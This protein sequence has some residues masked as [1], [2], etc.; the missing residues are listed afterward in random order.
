MREYSDNKVFLKRLSIDEFKD[1]SVF[2]MMKENPAFFSSFYESNE[3]LDLEIWPIEKWDKSD[4]ISILVRVGKRNNGTYTSFFISL[5][6][7]NLL[8]RSGCYKQDF[9][10]LLHQ[11]LTSV[12]G[13]EYASHLF[14]KRVADAMKEKEELLGCLN[15]GRK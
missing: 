6:D 3:D 10:Y 8:Y 7:F 9:S 14:E 13:D 1:L 2:I 11:Y 4:E 15:N 12:F 5:N